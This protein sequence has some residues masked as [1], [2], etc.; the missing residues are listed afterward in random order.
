MTDHT[1]TC[2]YAVTVN[3]Y[4]SLCGSEYATNTTGLLLEFYNK[5]EK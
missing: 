3:G 1:Y 4:Y 2:C 5:E